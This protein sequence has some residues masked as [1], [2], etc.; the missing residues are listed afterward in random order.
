ML[1]SGS[2]GCCGQTYHCPSGKFTDIHVN[3]R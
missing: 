2:V 1:E 3:E